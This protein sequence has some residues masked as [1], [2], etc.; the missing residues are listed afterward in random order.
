MRFSDSHNNQHKE[1]EL[2]NYR[3]TIIESATRGRTGFI[4]KPLCNS[5]LCVLFPSFTKSSRSV[6]QDKADE[7]QYAIKILVDMESQHCCLALKICR[8]KQLLHI[9]S[10]FFFLLLFLHISHFTVTKLTIVYMSKLMVL[11]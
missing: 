1:I 8:K 5:A 3:I 6:R 9:T 11:N 2:G 4:K 10:T 7:I